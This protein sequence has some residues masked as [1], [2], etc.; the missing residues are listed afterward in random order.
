MPRLRFRV[1]FAVLLAVTQAGI[2]SGTVSASATD[3]GSNF[4]SSPPCSNSASCLQVAVDVL[5]EA[6]SRLGQPAYSLPSDFSRLPPAQQAFVL[7]NLDRLRYGLP[8]VPGLTDEL[9]RAAAAG[10][11]ADRDPVAAQS[12]ITVMTSNWAGAYRDFPLAYE[13]WMYDDGPGG[14]NLDCSALTSAG[15]WGHRHNVLWS[16]S[17][18]GAVA[19]GAAAVTDYRGMRSYA[20]LIVQGDDGYRPDYVY[21]WAQAVA[22]GA[23]AGEASGATASPARVRADAVLLRITRLRVR[24]HSLW[25]HIVSSRRTQ[26]SCR[27]TRRGGDRRTR[28]RRCGHSPVFRRLRRG[29]YTL[30]VRAGR[31]S[32]TCAVRIR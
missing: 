25:A 14:V 4:F 20:M 6:R 22:S 1:A 12:S 2:R 13:A 27:L 31:Q 3:P 24:G 16:F 5:D 9:D 18:T 11:A 30:R 29:V 21:T 26:V 15:C 10:A 23:G 32:V 28:L 7:A 17:G 8:P 19:M